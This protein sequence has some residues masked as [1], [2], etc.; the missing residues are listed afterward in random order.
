M[1]EPGTY[2]F[3]TGWLLANVDNKTPDASVAYVNNAWIRREDFTFNLSDSAAFSTSYYSPAGQ[4]DDW[5]WTPAIN[6][7][8]SIPT[9]LSWNAVT[10][11]P[12]FPTVMKC[13]L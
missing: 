9:R 10:Y 4:A 5:M 1:A 11:D 3:P 6:L 8:G 7:T 2:V 12:V 13:V